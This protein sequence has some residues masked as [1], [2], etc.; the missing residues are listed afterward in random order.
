M[1]RQSAFAGIANKLDKLLTQFESNLAKAG[2]S[3]QQ[4]YW[5]MY[6]APISAADNALKPLLV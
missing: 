3:S 4:Q 6:L 5:M 1:Q 2:L